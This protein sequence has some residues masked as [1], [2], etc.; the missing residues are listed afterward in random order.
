MSPRALLLATLLPT[1]VLAQE[2]PPAVPAEKPVVWK[3][4][5]G[6]GLILT[7][8]NSESTTFNGG[9]AGSR[10]SANWIVSL[11]ADGTFGKSRAAAG[12]AMEAS[13][14]KGGGLVR[15]DRKFDDTWTA[16]ALA[17][18]GFDHV[19]AIEYR[20]AAELGASALWLDQKEADWTRLSLR[21][22]LG[23]RYGYEARRL[24]YG[25]TPGALPGVEI[26]ALRVGLAFRY[27]FTKEAFFTEEAELLPTLTDHGRWLAKSVSRLTTR[28]VGGIALGAAYTVTY[29]SDPA[30]G[31]KGTDTTLAV[32]IE[33]GF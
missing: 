25:P 27:G 30:P 21:T 18:I 7:T 12:G 23:F 5:L 13:A 33:V 2:A 6:A 22:D 28:L 24:Y 3:G 1:L 8:G 17:G 29:D 16:Y 32:L 4:V 10:E 26:K 19:A 20:T 14:W 15:L 11:K 9:L 31:K